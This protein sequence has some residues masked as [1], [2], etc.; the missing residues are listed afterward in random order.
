MPILKKHNLN[1]GNTNWSVLDLFF[2]KW[3]SGIIKVLPPFQIKGEN[4]LHLH[5]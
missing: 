4:K 3:I 1:W 2:Q 5:Y